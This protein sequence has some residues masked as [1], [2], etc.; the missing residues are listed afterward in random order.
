M[1]EIRV[2]SLEKLVIGVLCQTRFEKLKTKFCKRNSNILFLKN[3]YSNLFIEDALKI[4]RI[5]FKPK[6]EELIWKFSKSSKHH[7]KF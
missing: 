2:W 3:G 7:E 1:V 4:R 6:A 5:S